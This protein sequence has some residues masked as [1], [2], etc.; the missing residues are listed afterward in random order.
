[1][2]NFAW[3]FTGAKPHIFPRRIVHLG[4]VWDCVGPNLWV[5][6]A[7]SPSSALECYLRLS[8][9]PT[10]TALPYRRD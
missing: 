7:L 4:R 3:T 9:E 5:L 2:T 6:A 10:P 1:M 8:R